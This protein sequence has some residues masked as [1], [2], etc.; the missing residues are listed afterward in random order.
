MSYAYKSAHHSSP[1]THYSSDTGQDDRLL[2]GV[3]V[4]HLGRGRP[5]EAD[6]LLDLPALRPLAADRRLRA[7]ADGALELLL[8]RPAAA[9]GVHRRHLGLRLGPAAQPQPCGALDHLLDE[10]VGHA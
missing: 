6:P 10:L 4:E 3:E 2:L 7:P 1:F 9:R 5:L 8:D